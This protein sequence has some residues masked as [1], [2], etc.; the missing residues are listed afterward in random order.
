[1]SEILRYKLKSLDELDTTE[2]AERIIIENL[3]LAPKPV[4]ALSEPSSFGL[5]D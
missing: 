5:V 1:M 3:F 4:S 2:A